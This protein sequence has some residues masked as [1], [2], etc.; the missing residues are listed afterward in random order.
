MKGVGLIRVVEILAGKKIGGS[1]PTTPVEK[2]NN[3]NLVLNF[4]RENKIFVS[5]NV[6]GT[7]KKIQGLILKSHCK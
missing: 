7:N 1:E 2:V 5:S 6:S 3:I 4:L